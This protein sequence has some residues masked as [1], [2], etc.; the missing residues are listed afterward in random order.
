MI[1]TSSETIHGMR[2]VKT[3][4]LATG[5]VTRSCGFMPGF[6]AAIKSLL[7]GELDEYTK[8]LAE[9]REHALDRM[10]EHARSLGANAIISVRFASSEIARSAA[11]IMVYGTAVVMEEEAGPVPPTASG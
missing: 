2:V 9:A 6:I 5:A 8:V 1:V 10:R 4:G 7:G 11:E 3:L